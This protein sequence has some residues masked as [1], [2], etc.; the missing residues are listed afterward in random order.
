MTPSSAISISLGP[1]NYYEVIICKVSGQIWM[2][3]Y[4]LWLDEFELHATAGPGDEVG[5]ARVVQQGHQELPELQRSTP[6][7]RGALAEHAAPLLLD[8]TCWATMEFTRVKL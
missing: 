7:V 6:L 4:L 1:H 5:V 2:V 8:L 3:S